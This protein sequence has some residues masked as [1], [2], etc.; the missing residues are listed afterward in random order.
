MGECAAIFAEYGSIPF[1]HW[2]SYEKTEL[3]KDI[4]KCGDRESAASRVLENLHDLRPVVENAF[5][6][7]TP[8]YGLKSIEKIAGYKRTLTEADGKWSMATYIEAIETEDSAKAS[9]LMGEILNYNEEDLHAMWTVYQW[10][11]AQS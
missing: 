10:I 8:S 5:V 7:P 3:N 11:I 6:L 2:S 9:K 1:V 4:K